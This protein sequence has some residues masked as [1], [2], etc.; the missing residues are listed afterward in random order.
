MED[1]HGGLP[2][3]HREDEGVW[4]MCTCLALPK[5]SCLTISEVVLQPASKVRDEGVIVGYACDDQL[6]CIFYFDLV[7]THYM[8]FIWTH[9]WDSELFLCQDLINM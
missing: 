6:K 9:R 7:G 2:I 4:L 1:H 8:E 5:V 3:T